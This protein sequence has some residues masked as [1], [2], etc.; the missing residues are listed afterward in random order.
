MKFNWGVCLIYIKSL[1]FENWCDNKL[2]LLFGRAINLIN[3]KLLYNRVVKNSQKSYVW[4][5]KKYFGKFLRAY[6]GCLG[7]ERR[8]RTQLPAIYLGEQEACFDPGVS[9]WGNPIIVMYSHSEKKA[10][11]GKWN[12]S[13]P[14]G[15][16]I[17]R[18]S[19]SRGDRNGKSPNLSLLA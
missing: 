3:L 17:E 1:F 6:G 2:D 13:V 19:L 10:N 18:D 5:T 15:K 11:P 4:Q 14:G 9:E 12:I 7:T 8:W 16:E